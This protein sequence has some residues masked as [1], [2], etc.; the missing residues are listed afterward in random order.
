LATLRNRNSNSLWG[1]IN[2]IIEYLQTVYGRV[3]PQMLENREQE[4]RTMLYN[5]KYPI[6]MVFNAVEDFVDYVEL[7]QQP[8]TPRQ[9]ITRVYTILNKTGRFKTA[10]TEWN[11]KTELQKTWVAFKEH[12]RRAHQD[13]CETTDVTLEESEFQRNNANLA[14]QIV[15]G[16]QSAM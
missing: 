2:E 9:T 15:D 7:G 14:Q 16:I 4:L 3:S 5:P 13:F 1:T 12:F 11:R 8:I 6:N 10:T